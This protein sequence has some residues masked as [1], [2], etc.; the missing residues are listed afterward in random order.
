[1]HVESEHWGGIVVVL[2][3]VVGGWAMLFAPV[4]RAWLTWRGRLLVRVRVG[5]A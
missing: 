2:D 5:Q 4:G 3:D 1:V